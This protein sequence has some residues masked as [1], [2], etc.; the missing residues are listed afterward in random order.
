MI[1][2]KANKTL[3]IGWDAADWKAINPLIE[4]GFLPNLQK[5]IKGGVSGK[6]ATLDPPLSPTLWTSIATGKRPYKHGILGFTEP[7]EDGSGIQPVLNISRKCKA[8]WN[9]FTQ[10]DIKSHVVGWWPS[11]PAEPINGTYISNFYQK[12]TFPKGKEEL[13]EWPLMEGCIHP[14]E[15]EETYAKLRFHPMELTAAH[16]M[17]FMPDA[18]EVNMQDPQ[19]NKMVRSLQKTTADCTTIQS[20]ITHILSNKE[21]DFAAVY[22]DAIDHYGHG[23]MKFHP[24]Q[25]DHIPDHLFKAFH[26]VIIAGY[27]YH[28]MLLGALLNL[29]D[30]HTNVILISDHGFH[31]DHLRIKTMPKYP[32]APAL[33]H[34]LYGIIV[35]NGP[36]FKKDAKIH[37][38]SLI[39]ITPTILTLYNQPVGHDMDGRVLSQLFNRNRTVEYIESWE[40][41]TGFDGSHPDDIRERSSMN[42]ETLN[43][44]V[45]LGYIDK[46]HPNAEK[47]IK[48]TVSESNFWKAKSLIDGGLPIDAIP[49]LEDLFDEFP[50]H[51]RYG[52]VLASAYEK[53]GQA[54]QSARVLDLVN[55]NN[56]LDPANILLNE[57]KYL[58]SK[59]LPWDAINKYVQVRE[60]YPDNIDNLLYLAKEMILVQEL[61]QALTLYDK[62]LDIDFQN[63]HAFNGRGVVYNAQKNYEKAAENYIE[64]LS[65]MYGQANIHYALGQCLEYLGKENEAIQA[66]STAKQLSNK[67]ADVTIGERKKPTS[68]QPYVKKEKEIIVVSGLPRS[69]TSM[70][71]QICQAGGVPVFTDNLRKADDNNQKGYYEHQAI[72]SLA[73]DQNIMDDIP[74]GHVVKVVAPLIKFLPERY[75]YKIIFMTREIQEIMFS[76]EKML[77]RLSEDTNQDNDRNRSIENMK[78]AFEQ[79]SNDTIALIK[80]KENMDI[81]EFPYGTIN[82]GNIAE[83]LTEIVSFLEMELHVDKMKSVIDPTLYREKTKKS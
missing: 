30:E 38:A 57:G 51:I 50:E 48:K 70:M 16:I 71:M 27:R 7:K 20:A 49:I 53:T 4:Q 19:I 65:L 3:L 47:A 15:M 72:K 34:S 52:Q 55:K 44:L 37:G 9:M 66:Y 42:E 61:N 83:M 40:H 67:D 41:V 22:Y 46:P 74:A 2:K 31:P 78:A 33:E 69:G 25:Q 35:A 17:P 79:M 75:S 58:S 36:D 81:L 32:A 54:A 68:D 10:K 62:I 13:K 45:E 26:N 24:P 82:T 80:R 18:L 1:R 64:S 76:Q 60:L 8:I 39:D 56:Q 63:H 11:H 21:W 28:D 6:L 12:A 43:Q 14:K 23:F 73:S 29:T 77:D 5:L 59:G